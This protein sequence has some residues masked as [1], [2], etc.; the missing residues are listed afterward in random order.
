MFIITI[1]DTSVLR[2]QRNVT[3]CE[4]C[5]RPEKL[6]HNSEQGKIK[7]GNKIYTKEHRSSEPQLS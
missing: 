3:V 5:Q 1:M 4:P 6:D 2:I 7:T